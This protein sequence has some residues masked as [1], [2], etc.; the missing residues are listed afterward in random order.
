[1]VISNSQRK[2]EINR[3]LKDII[4][5]HVDRP[6]ER[7]TEVSGLYLVK[8]T[9]VNSSHRCFSRPTCSLIVQGSKT[10]HIGNEDYAYG[11]NQCL[12]CGVDMPSASCFLS[13]D[14]KP[15]LSLYFNLDREIL[16]DLVMSMRPE[17]RPACGTKAPS[18]CA[19]DA[20]VEF[21]GAMLHMAEL[22]D[23]PSQIPV[24]G[25][26]VMRELHYLL[27]VSPHG[28]ALH[29]LFK[30]GTLNHQIVQAISIM[31]ESISKPLRID[32]LARLVNMSVSSLHRHFKS[33]TGYSPLQYH[34]NL[35]LYEAQRLMLVDNMGAASAAIAVGYESPTQF[36]REYK[37][38]FGEPPYRDISRRRGGF[39]PETAPT[40]L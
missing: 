28:A 22:L 2:D 1:M 39:G 37:R 5:R 11:E 23:R 19:G 12:V 38:L 30:D 7:E 13:R 8:R 15:F 20:S 32:S 24:M 35:R 4:L 17:D 26:L 27:L 36:S 31:K 6:E 29:N 34:K 18:V 25:P 21:M 14:D 9:S 40:A 16:M 3:A 33:V 10:A